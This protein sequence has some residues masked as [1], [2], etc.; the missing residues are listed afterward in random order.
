M[1]E[2]AK[3]KTK[4]NQLR[5]EGAEEDNDDGQQDVQC[6]PSFLC[7]IQCNR[8]SR[9]GDS[10]GGSRVRS[11]EMSGSGSSRVRSGDSSGST[12]TIHSIVEVQLLTN[13]AVRGIVGDFQ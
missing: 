8:Y 2:L 12:Y 4:Q 11:G 6:F 13:G 3:E 7:Y 9:S 1:L 5:E 10:S